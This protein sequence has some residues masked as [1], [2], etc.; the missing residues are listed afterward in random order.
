MQN[1]Q[2][3][4]SSTKTKLSQEE[5]LELFQDKE[6]NQNTIA[7]SQFP[8]V[9]WL[10]KS[11]S[12]TTNKDIDELFSDGLEAL[13]VAINTFNPDKNTSFTS[14]ARTCIQNYF[15]RTINTDNIIRLPSRYDKEIKPTAYTFTQLTKVDDDYEFSISST[16]TNDDDLNYSYLS[17]E[18][19]LINLIKE[20]LTLPNWAYIVISNLGLNLDK[21][22]TYLELAEE[23]NV[24]K[25]YVG[26]VN[27]NGL[28][29]L[30]NNQ[31]FK[32]K[33]KELYQLD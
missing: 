33:L 7:A 19:I 14:Y 25:Q 9:H 22:K 5:I 2:K 3:F 23:L 27:K 29:K 21:K 16:I 20:H 17:N 8:L 15:N 31:Q 10:A 28:K 32:S 26:Q 30:M 13:S 6:S 4:I 1:L 11:Y 18:D 12:T 24:T